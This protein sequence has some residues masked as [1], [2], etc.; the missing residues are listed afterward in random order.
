MT[1]RTGVLRKA[2]IVLAGCFVLGAACCARAL[3]LTEYCPAHVGP[4]H[5]LDGSGPATL[6]A[7]VLN[8]ESAR[9]VQGTVMVATSAGWYRVKFPSTALV[10]RT[11][12]YSGMFGDLSRTAY[13]S[14]AV[15]VRFPSPVGIEA[16][17]VSDAQTS[18]EHDFGWDSKG[19]FSCLPQAS[20]FADEAPHNFHGLVQKFPRTDLT[21]A[22]AATASIIAAEPA[23]SP[24]NDACAK[25]FSNV[26]VKKAVSPDY[27]QSERTRRANGLSIVEVAVNAAGNVTDAWTFL[28]S[29]SAAFDGA[30]LASAE[31]STYTPG[32]V[33]C[34][35][36]GGF[37]LFNAEFEP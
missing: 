5:P 3:A 19:D 8:A 26:A 21:S 36:A 33:F 30:A 1:I 29:G 18:G 23:T 13:D 9:S 22:P 10:E 35:P 25:P 27:P 14:A 6:Y 17:Y 12:A 31:A 34:Q 2:L 11:Y 7:F 28:S 20:N 4:F 16:A 15:Y 37:Y 32:V 24:G